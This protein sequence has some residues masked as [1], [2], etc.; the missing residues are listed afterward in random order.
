MSSYRRAKQRA[1]AEFERRFLMRAIKCSAGNVSQAA[2]LI[3]T[4]RRHLGRLLKKH[5]LEP[6]ALVPTRR[7]R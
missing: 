1:L 6:L 5:G 3:N 7:A 4:E 2:R